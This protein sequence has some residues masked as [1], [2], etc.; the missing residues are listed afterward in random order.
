MMPTL[1]RTKLI[2][3]GIIAIILFSGDAVAVDLKEKTDILI[4]R[5]SSVLP[6]QWRLEK[7]D[8]PEK[9]WWMFYKKSEFIEIRLVGPRMSGYRYKLPSGETKD[10]LYRNEAIYLWITPS[11]F[12]DGWTLWRRF[13]YHFWKAYVK[14]PDIIPTRFGVKIYV[15]PGCVAIEE[16][17][18]ES[19]KYPYPARPIYGKGAK[20]GSW[21]DWKADIA[22]AVK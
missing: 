8:N 21:P 1:K 7:V 12:D 2:T 16:L 18:P 14:L 9:S 19:G 5:L 11:S 22:K 6:D 4:N 13:R 17:I 20:K 10:I 3:I 15:K